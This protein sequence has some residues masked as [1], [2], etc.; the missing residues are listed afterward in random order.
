VIAVNPALQE[1]AHAKS[2]ALID[3]LAAALADRGLPLPSAVLAAQVGRAAFGRAMRDWRGTSA[4]ELGNLIAS[5][6]DEVRSL[7]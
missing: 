1:R 6:F 7:G 5:A 2:A 4:S 3:A